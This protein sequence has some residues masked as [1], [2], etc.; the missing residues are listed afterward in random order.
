MEYLGMSEEEL[1]RTADAKNITVAKLISDHRK[2]LHQLRLAFIR[3]G[4][5]ELAGRCDGCLHELIKLNETAK[6]KEV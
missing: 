4:D 1:Q 2:G 5:W 6:N 3:A